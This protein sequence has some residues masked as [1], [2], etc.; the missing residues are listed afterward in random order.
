MKL[1][2]GGLPLNRSLV[3]V[4]VPDDIWAAAEKTTQASLP[5]GWEAEPAGRVRIRFGNDW[6]SSESSAVLVVP[7]VIVLEEYNLLINPAHPD[8]ARATASKIGKWFY[9]PSVA[10]FGLHCGPT[11][12]YFRTFPRTR[13]AALTLGA[14]FRA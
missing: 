9:D 12:C 1:D 2:A 7:S 10:R 4:A 5:V 6:A 8:A 11:G 3:E 13:A 14:S